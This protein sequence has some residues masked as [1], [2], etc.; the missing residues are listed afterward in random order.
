M[1]INSIAAA[2]CILGISSVNIVLAD[3]LN[4]I[5]SNI[6]SNNTYISDDIKLLQNKNINLLEPKHMITIGGTIKSNLIF[7]Y[8]NC[9]VDNNNHIGNS[10]ALLYTIANINDWSTGYIQLES[11]NS[12][13]ININIPSITK[14]FLLIGNL[15]I[16][17]VYLEIGYKPTNIAISSFINN[18]I[19]QT[20]V[21]SVS[22]GINSHGFNSSFTIMNS[23]KN[24]IKNNINIVHSD[25]IIQNK[26]LHNLQNVKT[27]NFAL[28][29]TYN[30]TTNDNIHYQLGSGLLSS[31]SFNKDDN[32]QHNVDKKVNN[33][34]VD[35]NLKINKDNLT[36]VSEY[37]STINKDNL[38]FESEYG[39]GFFNQNKIIHH[40]NIVSLWNVGSS[41]NM[42]ICNNNYI[43]NINYSQCSGV[44]PA[45]INLPINYVNKINNLS[46][47]M[48]SNNNSVHTNNIHEYS[49]S[50]KT[51]LFNNV[52]SSVKYTYNSINTIQ[53]NYNN[54]NITKNT[55]TNNIKFDISA[56]F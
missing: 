40:H 41:Y 43:F 38:T 56:N 52:W 11:N 21:P 2:L 50:I 42:P 37:A 34:I 7:Q 3:N 53:T 23:C 6:V 12:F 9:N 29:M 17:P 35:L 44:S 14:A 45:N 31:S 47:I 24:S 8:G 51:K 32:L 54:I 13:P 20:T 30:N 4:K 33:A 48:N 18:I 55:D 22:L 46:N 39:S 28:K 49:V 5:S 1:K 27:N 19:S 25:N 36:F 10:Q 26:Y 16:S 15:N